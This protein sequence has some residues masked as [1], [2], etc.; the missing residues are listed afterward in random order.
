MISFDLECNNK[1]RFDGVFKDYLAFDDQLK[2]GMIE[3]PACGDSKIK[4]LFTGCSIQPGS[5]APA[6]VNS[7]PEQ[8]PVNMFEMIRTLKEYVVN[9][10]EN[11]GSNFADSAKAM[12][13][14]IEKER[15][16]Y[17]ESTPEEIKELIDEGIDILPIP[18]VDKI[19]N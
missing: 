16:I 6:P 11:V 5:S 17:G 7:K 9:N 19:E 1:H 18:S 3:C 12:Y 10:F 2:K 13:Y 8:N 14:G 15:N 4:R